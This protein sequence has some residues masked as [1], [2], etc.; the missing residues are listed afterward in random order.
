MIDE[1]GFVEFW[2][3]HSQ[4]AL[5]TLYSVSA[6]IK[7]QQNPLTSSIIKVS[8]HFGVCERIAEE[9]KICESASFPSKSPCTKAL[10][11]LNQM[12]N[13]GG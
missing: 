8:Q 5:Q 7:I 3:L 13:L 2:G 12:P 10:Y 11:M 6:V 9:M 1:V 4:L